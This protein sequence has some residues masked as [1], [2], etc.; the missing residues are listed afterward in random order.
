MGIAHLRSGGILPPR[1]LF[2]A[3]LAVLP[4]IAAAEPLAERLERVIDAHPVAKRANLGILVVDAETG[5]TLFAKNEHQLL[6]PASNGKIYTSAFALATWGK[7]KTFKT[8]IGEYAQPAG[9]KLDGNIALLAEGDPVLDSKTLLQMIGEYVKKR[10]LVAISGNVEVQAANGDLMWPFVRIKGTGWMW[11]DDPDTDSMSIARMMLDYN[12]AT[13]VAEPTPHLEPPSASPKLVADMPEAARL[14]GDIDNLFAIR[15]PFEEEIEL[16]PWRPGESG[17]PKSL[18]YTV[19][20][21]IPWIEGVAREGFVAA[22]V[23]F[24]PLPEGTT[25]HYYQ[26]ASPV[27]THTSPPLSEILARFM[28]PSQNAIGE[29]LFL[30]LAEHHGGAWDWPDAEKAERA[31]LEQTVGLAPDEFRLV[32]GSGLS[33]YNLITA[34][35]T[36]KLLRF[37]HAHPDFAVYDASLPV[38]GVDGTLAGRMKG[39]PAAGRVHA[40]T[41]TMSGVSCLSGYAPAADGRTLAFSILVNGY[42]GSSAPA[43]DL[44]DKVCIELVSPDGPTTARTAFTVE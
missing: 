31:W 44:Q 15:R 11:D 30:N 17:A 22:G 25:R 20:Q 34:A 29:M 1:L 32:D 36:V 9:G 26:P 38:A 14:R 41:G 42:V 39:T 18:K 8:S 37:M 16:L 33:R 19:L 2:A 10:Q 24:E 7:D 35:G 40:K 27:L 28:K 5:E 43:R 6:T 12:V 23:E 13:V 21:P 4:H 3:T